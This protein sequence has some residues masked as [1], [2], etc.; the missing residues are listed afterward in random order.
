M[1]DRAEL[2]ARYASMISELASQGEELKEM[3]RNLEAQ[4]TRLEQQIR[5][6][7]ERRRVLL[8]RLHDQIQQLGPL[9]RPLVE[10]VQALEAVIEDL[11]SAR[12]TLTEVKNRESSLTTLLAWVLRQLEVVG[13]LR[14]RLKHIPR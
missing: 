4:R 9:G 14:E 1:S 12:H 2:A 13:E 5:D 8:R 6:L 3:I 11:E 10:T 7:Q